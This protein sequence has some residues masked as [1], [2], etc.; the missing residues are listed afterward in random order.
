MTSTPLRMGRASSVEAAL[1][2]SQAWVSYGAAEFSRDLD[3]TL[4]ASPENLAR[5][6]NAPVDLC[7]PSPSPFL[8]SSGNISSAGTLFT[9][10]VIVRIQRE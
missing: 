2:G 6:G 1:M 9:S 3:I 4:L 10:A 7:R 5:L 8:R